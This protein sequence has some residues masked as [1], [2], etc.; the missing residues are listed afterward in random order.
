MAEYF[1]SHCHI[2]TADSSRDNFTVKKWREGEENSEAL[3]NSSAKSGV[4]RLICVGTDLE[5][6]RLAVEFVQNHKNA[7]A[8]VGVHPHE[9][10][11]IRSDDLRQIRKLIEEDQSRPTAARKI[12]AIGE[13]GLDYYYEHSPKKIQ[14]ELLEQFLDLAASYDLPVIF[15]VRE[16]FSDFWPV[17]ANFKSAGR[18]IRGVLHS[19]TADVATLEK[20]LAEGLYIGLNGIVT[21]TKDESQLEM[22]KRVPLDNLLLET[23]AP[24]LTPRPFRG[25]MCKPEHVVNT[26]EFL[27]K[28]RGEQLENLA[29]QTTKNAGQLFEIK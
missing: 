25:K 9:A 12:A 23:D 29:S 2:H 11:Q 22:A 21:F 18:R 10:Q 19:F 5:D 24:Y 27:A 17:Y 3:L 20:A 26:A 6:S 1:D 4:I 14:T 8:S 7:W 15:H 13:V 16:A 28:L